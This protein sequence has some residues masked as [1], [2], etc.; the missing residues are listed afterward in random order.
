[1]FSGRC[2][3]VSFNVAWCHEPSIDSITM[4]CDCGAWRR[5]CH[6][7]SH[8]KVISRGATRA[9]PLY[10]KRQALV[11]RG[12]AVLAYMFELSLA[13]SH[14]RTDTDGFGVLAHK[15]GQLLFITM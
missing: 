7:K 14:V 2:C 6:F 15:H 11:R 13:E 9:A 1:M 4:V 10:Y 12:P 8:E 3:W 5:F